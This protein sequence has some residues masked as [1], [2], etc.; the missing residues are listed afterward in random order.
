MSHGR[1]LV[2]DDEPSIR[3]IM[4]AALTTSGYEVEDARSGEE[5]LEKGA[6]LIAH[7]IEINR[8]ENEADLIGRGAVADL[9][10]KEK[11]PI[12]LIKLKEVY[13]F[14]EETIDS[15]EDVADV[16][17]F[18]E[19]HFTP[20][21]V[22]VKEQRDEF[23]RLGARFGAQWTPTTLL[24]DG[25]GVE[26]Y[27]IE[28][29]LPKGEFMGQ[30]ALGLAKAAFAAADYATAGRLFQQVVDEHGD[31]DAAPEALYWAGVSRYRATN[32]ASALG[33]TARAFAERYQ[34]SNWAR[35]ASVWRQ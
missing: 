2:V 15:C 23:Q 28:G 10:N 33:D 30:L 16:I 13:D 19:Q 26:R 14:F 3:R 7:S 20:V 11:D 12:R 1:I 25:Q 22:H 6:P 18:I 4:R 34:E 27:R 9:F 5:A 35:K 8:L 17:A 24:I 32:D 31:T 29:F 21:R